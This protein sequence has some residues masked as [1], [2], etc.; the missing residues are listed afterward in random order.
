MHKVRT[1]L[2]DAPSSSDSV[3]PTSLTSQSSC[4]C[5]FWLLLVEEEL[6]PMRPGTTRGMVAWFTR[7]RIRRD[8]DVSIHVR[9]SSIE[10]NKVK[11]VIYW[12]EWLVSS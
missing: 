7:V 11:L 6:E 4:C 12:R 1:V 3:L 9:C 5:C 10:P 8:G 2:S